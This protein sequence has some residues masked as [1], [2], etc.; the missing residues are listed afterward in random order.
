MTDVTPLHANETPLGALR[1]A[2]SLAELW[3]DEVLRLPA[4]E[5]SQ[6]LHDIA[7]LI[8]DAL[9]KLSEVSPGAIRAAV[10]ELR[11][12]ARAY[13]EDGTLNERYARD[14]AAAILKAALEGE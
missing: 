12:A 4:G 8:R 6:A 13:D 9:Q 7:R 10:L 5:H 1:N 11:N 2:L 14:T 3:K